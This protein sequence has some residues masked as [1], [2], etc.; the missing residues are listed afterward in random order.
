MPRL[1]HVVIAA[2]QC[3]NE[4]RCHLLRAYAIEHGRIVGLIVEQEHRVGASPGAQILLAEH[5]PEEAAQ[6]S[7]VI[8]L[9]GHYTDDG[10]IELECLPCK[11]TLQVSPRI[12]PAL[13]EDVI[14]L[15]KDEAMGAP[16]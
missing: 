14:R 1:C 5:V 15:G 8:V 3:G 11:R 7:K 10:A 16:A 13:V 9:F 12:G 2:P 4:A 6:H